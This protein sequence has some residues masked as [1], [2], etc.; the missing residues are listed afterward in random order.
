MNNDKINTGFL[1]NLVT[2]YRSKISEDAKIVDIITFS[3]ASWGL[4]FT[5]FPMQRLILKKQAI[6]SET[7]VSDTMRN[8]GTENPFSDKFS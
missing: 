4:N 2:E 1:S 8:T 7:A 3:E 6:Y 5:L